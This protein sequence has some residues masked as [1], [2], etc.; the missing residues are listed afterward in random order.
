MALLGLESFAPAQLWS[1]YYKLTIQ[2]RARR[3]A[4]AVVTANNVPY[5]AAGSLEAMC[6]SQKQFYFY[7][8]RHVARPAWETT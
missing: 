4:R 1:P 8:Y 3:A 5:Q 2:E 7:P 6:T